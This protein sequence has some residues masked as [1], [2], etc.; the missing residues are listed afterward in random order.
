M[1]QRLPPPTTEQRAATLAGKS[2]AYTLKRSKR[3]QTIGL[4]I[5]ER[6]LT[7]SAPLQASESWLGKVLQDKASWV[8]E[9]LSHWQSSKMPE[10][11]YEDGESIP[12]LGEMLLLSVRPGKA[13]ALLQGNTL[14]ICADRAAE[15]SVV[16][17]YRCQALELYQARAVFYGAMLGV[18]P[19]VV[20]LSTAKKQWGCCTGRGA[21]RLNLQLI[22]LPLRLIDYVVVHELAHLR[23]MN[24]SA[25]FWQ[26]VGKVCPDYA[27]LRCELKAIRL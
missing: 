2:I 13:P 4:R 15:H 23:E 6:G 8:V 16:Q 10:I 9:K 27:R 11:R 17:W 24:H 1:Q 21:I 20:R 5:D 7:V 22:K 14:L 25:A 12:Y 3:R 19:T 26:V 18:A